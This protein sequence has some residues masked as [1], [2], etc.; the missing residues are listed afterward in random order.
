MTARLGRIP[1]VDGILAPEQVAETA[2]SIAA[3][4]EPSGAIPWT[5]GQHADIWNHVEAAMGLLVGG[6]VDAAHRA[7]DWCIATQREDG[8]WD[9]EGRWAKE[10]GRVY[11][12][13]LNCLC[14]EVYYRY[15]RVLGVRDDNKPKGG[16]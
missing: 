2:A 11:T 16:K 13:A 1:Y 8:S 4:Q 7:Y 9:P 12:T 3:M 14:M 6:Q 10:G 5:T 15:G